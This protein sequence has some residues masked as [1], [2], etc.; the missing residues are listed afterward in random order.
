MTKKLKQAI[1]TD[2]KIAAEIRLAEAIANGAL[3]DRKYECP[4]VK[5]EGDCLRCSRCD[6]LRYANGGRK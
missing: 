2:E 6:Y 4:N 1:I 5:A 3:R